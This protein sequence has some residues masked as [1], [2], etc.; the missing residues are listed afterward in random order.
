MLLQE[1]PQLDERLVQIL[2]ERPGSS[3]KILHSA[4]RAGGSVYTLR[5]VYK[6]LAKLIDQGIVLKRGDAY[7]LRL[8]W[9]MNLQAFGARAYEQST[10]AEGL[11]R[12]IGDGAETL[13]ERFSDLRKLDRL[14][15]QLMLMLHKAFPNRVMCFWIPYQWFSVAH[16]FTAKQFYDAVTIGRHARLHIMGEDSFL[17]RA[18]LRDLPKSGKYSFAESPF[19]SE[20]QTYY[21][22]LAD[23][24]LTVRIDSETTARIHS[25]FESIRSERDLTPERVE[26]VFR[27]PARAS[28]T[29]ERNAKKARQLKKKFAEYFGVTVE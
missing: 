19:H 18:A 6:E 12:A 3:A 16:R 9:I 17:A 21:T 8:A 2:A 24:V 15:T 26:E 23:H 5:A 4:V 13:R 28:L 20:R 27:S 1:H 7:S 29:L 10:S 25:L 11:R 14:W 22:V